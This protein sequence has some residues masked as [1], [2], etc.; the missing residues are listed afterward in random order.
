MHHYSIN[1]NNN[2]GELTV[3]SLTTVAVN[4]EL[5]AK[6][7]VDLLIRRIDDESN[8]GR[9]RITVDYRIAVRESA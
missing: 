8:L 1:D 9:Q 2:D 6:Q 5:I 3:P 7:A 4:I